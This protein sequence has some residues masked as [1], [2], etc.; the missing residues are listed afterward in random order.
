MVDLRLTTTLRLPED[1]AGE[2][3]GILATRGAGKSYTSAVLCEELWATKVQFAV[4]DPTGVYWGL[5]STR[6]GQGEGLPITVLGGAH[7]DVPLEPTAGKLIADVLVDTGQSL[8]LDLSDFESKG[9]QTRFVTDLIER[10]YT[11]KARSRTTLHLV[12][13]EADEFAPQRALGRDEPRML[14]AMERIV[15]RGRSR[16]IGC[17]LI[18]QRSAALNKNVLDVVDTL[19]AMRMLSPRDRRAVNEWIVAKSEEDRAGVVDSLPRLATGIAWVWSP[20]RDILDQVQ[21]RKLRTFDSYATPKPGR[22]KVEPAVLAPIDIDVLGKQI[23]QT[24]ARSE[25]NDPATLHRRIR[26]LE[27]EV[28]KKAPA[29]APAAKP[30][31]VLTAAERTLL[32]RAVK[33][34]DNLSHKLAPIY[35][36]QLEVEKTRALGEKL[37]AE[38]TRVRE[39]PR[40]QRSYPAPRRAVAR[41]APAQSADGDLTGPERRILTAL[42][43]LDAIGISPAT[44]KQVAFLAGYS[45]N[46]AAFKNPLAAMKTKGWVT[47]PDTGHVELTT[48]GTELVPM[49]GKPLSTGELQ[50]RILVK[51]TG[52]QGKLMTV[53][54]EVY[55]DAMSKTDLA[56]ATDYSAD[57]AAFKNPLASLRSLGLVEYPRSGEARATEVGFVDEPIRTE[58]DG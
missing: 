54:W 37:R 10:L 11:L 56:A 4:L 12:I 14:G 48:N 36:M 50:D 21:V 42:V 45:P 9:A 27:R 25:A 8:I 33:A 2:A 32:D 29:S 31:P 24:K 17:T 5:R 28:Q 1:I 3:V 34:I 13:D 23:A 22:K 39:G 52:P 26:E 6:D 15:R 19:I 46:G 38:L 16:G 20:V 57:G 49:P 53:L 35:G 40:A 7:G 18:T 55:P 44:R 58:S 47:Y 30:E 43:E 51:L 41:A